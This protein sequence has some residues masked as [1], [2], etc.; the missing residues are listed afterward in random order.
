V[1]LF[2]T[3]GI[4][5]ADAPGHHLL[6]TLL[7]SPEQEIDLALQQVLST[8]KLVR[9][10]ASS[11]MPMFYPESGFFVLPELRSDGTAVGRMAIPLTPQ[12][13]VALVAADS[14]LGALCELWQPGVVSNYSVGIR[15][16]RV[17]LHPDAIE[18]MDVEFLETTL[19]N[20]RESAKASIE[21]CSNL[22]SIVAHFDAI[23]G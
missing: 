18:A 8:R 16:A 11:A 10:R 14:D 5:P 20:L 12:F 7:E 9:V 3:Q 1:L 4:R 13:A 15:S 23:S 17:V 6:A 19:S 21:L 2:P 22:N